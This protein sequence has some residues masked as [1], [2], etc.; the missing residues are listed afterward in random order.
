MAKCL[1]SLSIVERYELKTIVDD[2]HSEIE[3]NHVYIWEHRIQHNSFVEF[4]KQI[5]KH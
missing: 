3:A 5:R 1:T 4:R 2:R